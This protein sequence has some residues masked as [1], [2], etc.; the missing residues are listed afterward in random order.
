M[1]NS[2][3]KHIEHHDIK[4]LNPVDYYN[5]EL[6]PNTYEELEVKNFDL[7]LVRN[8]DLVLVN[9][10]HLNSIGTAIELHESYENYKIPVIAF[11]TKENYEK[12]HPWIKCSVNRYEETLDA[13]I[14]YILTFYRDICS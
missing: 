5:F 12:T 8:C 7:H 4:T 6:D 2:G 11:A 3:Y 14:D 9:L 13:A 10:N 1:E